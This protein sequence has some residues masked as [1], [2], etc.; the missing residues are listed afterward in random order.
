MMTTKT[1]KLTLNRESLRLLAT[2]NGKRQLAE[3]PRPKWA[4]AA[5]VSAI[6][7]LSNSLLPLRVGGPPWKG[8]YSPA[9]GFNPRWVEGRRPR[10]LALAWG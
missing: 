2:T 7:P 6:E 9:W 10:P 5:T 1:K 8:G 4:T 3:D